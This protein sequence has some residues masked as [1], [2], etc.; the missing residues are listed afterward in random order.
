MWACVHVYCFGVRSERGSGSPGTLDSW[1]ISFLSRV[2][3]VTS[4]RSYLTVGTESWQ[5][6][7]CSFR[8]FVLPQ[9]GIDETVVVI[10]DAIV[11]VVSFF[12][13]VNSR[14]LAFF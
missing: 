4:H 9:P 8:I 7:A 12:R 3:G 6:A 13:C 14:C 2:S 5:R 11:I 1:F 10:A